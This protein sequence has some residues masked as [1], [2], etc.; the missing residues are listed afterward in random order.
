ND[1]R[2]CFQ[3]SRIML[4][5]PK[6][7]YFYN[8]L[9]AISLSS[10]RK[11]IAENFSDYLFVLN[12]VVQCNEP[13]VYYYIKNSFYFNQQLNCNRRNSQIYRSKKFGN[14]K[15][16]CGTKVTIINNTNIAI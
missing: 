6:R 3:S 1:T 11:I 16:I 5:R 9:T 10:F 14:N 13:V 15:L 8:R 12:K 7:S 4:N 2:A